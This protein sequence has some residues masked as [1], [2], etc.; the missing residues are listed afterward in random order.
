MTL[1]IPRF[2]VSRLNALKDKKTVLSGSW[3]GSREC[4]GIPA[5][6]CSSV[7]LTKGRITVDQLGES[8]MFTQLRYY[9]DTTCVK[10][11]KLA[12]RL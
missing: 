9:V 7:L 12:I 8:P 4:Q 10:L 1:A 5:L 3:L 6:K 2:N 11:Y